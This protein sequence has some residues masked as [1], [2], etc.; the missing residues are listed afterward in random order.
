MSLKVLSRRHVGL[1][2]IILVYVYRKVL[3]SVVIG[4]LALRSTILNAVAFY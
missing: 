4:L 2:C 3:C 1:Y